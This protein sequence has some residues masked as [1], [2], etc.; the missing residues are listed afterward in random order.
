A[1]GISN[2]FDYIVRYFKTRATKIKDI[3]AL[4]LFFNQWSRYDLTQKLLLNKINDEVADEDL[5]F[6]LIQTL[7]FYRHETFDTNHLSTLQKKAYT[8]NPDQWCQWVN[9]YFQLLRHPWIKSLYCQNCS[10]QIRG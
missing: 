2:A 5:I 3:K 7:A 10:S 1:R 6:Y 8:L 9:D 4:A